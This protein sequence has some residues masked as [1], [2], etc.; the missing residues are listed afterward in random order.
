MIDADDFKKVNDNYGHIAGDKILKLLAKIFLNNIREYDKVY[1]Y[2]GE[3]FLMIFNRTT[4]PTVKKTAERILT[5]VRENKLIYKN[6]YIRITLSMGMTEHRKGETLKE[7]I[8]RAD[9]ALYQAKQIGKDRL[10]I[11]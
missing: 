3:E 5:T 9:R 8:E 11:L 7:V 6:S 1:R 4:L 2:G 10:V